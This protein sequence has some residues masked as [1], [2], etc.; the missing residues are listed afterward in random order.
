MKTPA[1]YATAVLLVTATLLAVGCGSSSD[2]A[3]DTTAGAT[4][5]TSTTAVSVPSTPTV[6]P[7]SVPTTE[8]PDTAVWPFA[9]GPV[10]YD[11]PVSAAT[12]FATTFLGFVDPIVGTFQ[13]G[14]SRSGEVAVQASDPGPVTTVLVRRLGA[15]DSWWVLGATTPNIQI[16]APDALATVT[17]PVT[18]SGQSTAFEATI[19]LEVRADDDL[20]PLVEGHTMGGS[21]GEMG[22]FTTDLTFTAPPVSGGAIV[23]KTISARDGNIAEAAVLRIHF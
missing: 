12:G 7:P 11:D 22:P 10:R 21:M 18:V 5:S 20:T 3:G 13:E 16:E 17:S 23:V 6:P 2:T 8:Q 14:D 1:R 4:T 9:S 19:N 15:D